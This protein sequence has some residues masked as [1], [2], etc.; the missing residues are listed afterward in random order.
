MRNDKRKLE[1]LKSLILIL[2]TF[3]NPLGFDA[4]F[5]AV[6]K[7]TGSFWKTDLI[8]YF[9]S[10]SFFGLWFYLHRKLKDREKKEDGMGVK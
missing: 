8:F 4:L 1:R 10:V 9:I 6:M 2:A 5:A 3:L 7:W